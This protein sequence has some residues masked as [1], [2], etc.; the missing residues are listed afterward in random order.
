MP[1]TSKSIFQQLGIEPVPK[2]PETWDTEI[3]KPGHT[4]GVP[5]VLFTQIPASKIEE[6]RNAYGGEELKKLK[7]L[8]AEKAA[9]KKA[10]KEKEKEKKKLKKEAAAAATAA[11]ALQEKLTIDDASESKEQNAA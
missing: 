6:W 7:A 2:I 5:Q 4:L 11:T 3:L 10:A 1:G 8:E 9:A